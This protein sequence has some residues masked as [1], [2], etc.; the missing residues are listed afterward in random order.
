MQ[1]LSKLLMIAT[2]IG[3]LSGCSGD[4]YKDA[5]DRQ[6][7]DIL[8]D[9]KQST[10]GYQPQAV[11]ETTVKPV[12]PPK[13]A[14]ERLPMT[15]T[16]PLSI[17]PMEPFRAMLP[18]G[19]LSPTPMQAMGPPAAQ[20]AAT[21]PSSKSRAYGIIA[22]ERRASGRLSLSPPG[23]AQQAIRMGLFTATGYAVGHGRDYSQ[24]MEDLYLTALDVT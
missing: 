20:V 11:A 16:P 18:F 14:F 10:L 24:A 15:P 21:Q 8:K 3:C 17:P 4:F 5:A 22:A 19:R 23:P 6:V 9:R 2:L 7:Y 13:R 12:D 1:S